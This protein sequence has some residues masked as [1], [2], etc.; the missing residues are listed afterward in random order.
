MNNK[1]L[2]STVFY[3]CIPAAADVLSGICPPPEPL[4]LGSEP[5]IVGSLLERRILEELGPHYRIVTCR[6]DEPKWY[7]EQTE[8]LRSLMDDDSAIIAIGAYR[9]LAALNSDATRM[10]VVPMATGIESRRQEIW[11]AAQKILAD[12]GVDVTVQVK[13]QPLARQLANAS[14]CNYETAKRHMAKAVRRAR[15][16]DYELPKRGGV[17]E[18]KGGRPRA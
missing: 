17:R 10:A 4:P 18:N 6:G 5:D 7:T 15:H 14:G 16:P 3:N 11:M 8:E 9:Y 13:L 12:S 1:R 2:D